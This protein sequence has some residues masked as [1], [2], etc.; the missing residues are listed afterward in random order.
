MCEIAVILSVCE[1]EKKI[2]RERERGRN[3]KKNWASLYI[4]IFYVFF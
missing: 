2:E 1:R 4:C 3:G